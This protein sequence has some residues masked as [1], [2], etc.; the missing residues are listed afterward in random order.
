MDSVT[1]SERVFNKKPIDWNYWAKLNNITPHQAAKLANRIDPLVWEYDKCELGDIPE[2][3]RVNIR[4]MEQ[5]LSNEQAIWNLKDLRTFLGNGAPARLIEAVGGSCIISSI[6]PK[7][8]PLNTNEL[9]D[10]GLLTNLKRKDMWF[11][12]IDAMT[13]VYY[14]AH[15]QIPNKHQ[16]WLSLCSEPLDGYSITVGKD[17]GGEVCLHTEIASSLSKSAFNKRWKKYTR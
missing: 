12:I 9:M 16:A 14:L 11:S 1:F 10:S 3:V 8:T 6:E 17:K 7:N 4:K 15:E 2:D 13:K 5:A